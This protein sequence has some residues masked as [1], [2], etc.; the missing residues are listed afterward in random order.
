MLPLATVMGHCPVQHCMMPA[1][2]RQQQLGGA[3]HL[4]NQGCGEVGVH[5][6]CLGCLVVHEAVQHGQGVQVHLHD[7]VEGVGV[8][9][10]LQQ[11]CYQQRILAGM[12]LVEQPFSCLSI[13]AVR[14]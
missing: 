1:A 5:G 7:Q 3:L 14:S 6:R 2:A 9:V 8:V 11:L 12:S 10:V 4:G 13:E